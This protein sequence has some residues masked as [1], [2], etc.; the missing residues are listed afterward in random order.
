MGE[1]DDRDRQKLL[2]LIGK[3]WEQLIG[4]KMW[5]P[6]LLKVRN[7]K[8]LDQII[9]R[10]DEACECVQEWADDVDSKVS[11]KYKSSIG[12]K[13][14]TKKPA[15]ATKSGSKALVRKVPAMKV[16]KTITKPK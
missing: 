12:R 13:S 8:V 6:S 4:G 3:E 7:A 15:A 16:I 14:I 5:K 11:F 10:L 1:D 9:V 2:N